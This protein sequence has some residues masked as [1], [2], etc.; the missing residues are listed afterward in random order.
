M[1]GVTMSNALVGMMCG[2]VEGDAR[3][4]DGPDIRLS[5]CI[6]VWHGDGGELRLIVQDAHALQQGGQQPSLTVLRE[7][8]VVGRMDGDGRVLSG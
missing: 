6:T 7:T 1:P 3:V 2:H 8:V 5:S 4:P